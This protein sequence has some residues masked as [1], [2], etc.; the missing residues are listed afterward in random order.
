MQLLAATNHANVIAFQAAGSAREQPSRQLPEERV[1]QGE[2]LERPATD[3][4]LLGQSAQSLRLLNAV[5]G[6]IEKQ[7][8]RRISPEAAIAAYRATARILT[9]REP[10]LNLQA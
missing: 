5:S 3:G 8:P 10:T 2:L 7:A 9:P 6:A 4:G 1:V